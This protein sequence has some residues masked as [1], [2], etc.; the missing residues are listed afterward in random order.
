[1]IS[2]PGSSERSRTSSCGRVRGGRWRVVDR[3]GRCPVIHDRRASRLPADWE[4]ALGAYAKL[5][6]PGVIERVAGARDRRGVP[7]GVG[8]L[9]GVSPHAV[10][11]DARAPAPVGTRIRPP[12]SRTGCVLGQP[13]HQSSRSRWPTCSTSWWPIS[14]ASPKNGYL[15]PVGTAGRP[16]ST[17]S[18]PC[19]HRSPARKLFGWR[20][21]TNEV[22]RALDAREEH[23]LR[24]LG[25]PRAGAREA[26]D[27]RVVTRSSKGAS[28]RCR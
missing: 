1:M 11:E 21:L 5:D 2:L 10:R 24:L 15:L 25:R 9:R 16:P 18:S 22:I 26:G 17:R 20:E 6:V 3:A 28:R 19:V 4:V 27:E 7:A 13:W 23:R 12:V 8:D 14:D